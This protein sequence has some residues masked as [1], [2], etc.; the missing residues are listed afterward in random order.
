MV[1]YF[2]CLLNIKVLSDTASQLLGYNKPNKGL[3]CAFLSPQLLFCYKTSSNLLIAFTRNGDL[4]NH[5]LM[6]SLIFRTKSKSVC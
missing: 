1:K 2:F 6:S 5:A 3:V 4:G